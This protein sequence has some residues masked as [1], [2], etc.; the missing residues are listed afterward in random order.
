MAA[1]DQRRA[2]SSEVANFGGGGV[3][4]KTAGL[5]ADGPPNTESDRV[6]IISSDGHA[7]AQMRDW[8]PYIPSRYHEEF[9]EFCDVYDEKGSRNNQ[10]SALAS[11]LDPEVV[12]DWKTRI[13]DPGRH[14]GIFDLKV[15]LDELAYHGAA[16]EVLFPDF[17][18]PFELYSPQLANRLGY[19]RT[20]EQINVA[21]SAY[22]RWLVD[23]CS[24][25]PER[26]AGQACVNW[27]DVDAA[28]AEIRWAKNAGL[29][30]VIL[31]FFS[32]EYPLF[33]PRYDPIWS[34]LEELEMPANSHA[35]ISG[36]VEYNPKMAGFP[37]A[38]VAVALY[39]S[40]LA[41]FSHQILNH[42]I[43]GGVLER[44]PKLQI[45]FT[46]QGTGWVIE[47]CAQMDYSWGGSF[48]RRDVREVVPLAPS[49]YF[50]RQ[51]H[52]GS[53]LFSKA[54]AEAREA[55]GVDK[56]TIGLDYPH[57]EGTWGNGVASH[58]A[59]MKATLGAAHVPPEDARLMM[60]E[61]A[62]KLWGFDRAALQLIVDEIGPS[63]TEI[64]TPPTTDEFPR[65]DVHKPL[66]QVY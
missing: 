34:T 11:R 51:C 20:D 35:A 47:A 13:L 59:Y 29:R 21:N 4:S 58:I 23:Y 36:I 12:D 49:E 14:N 37:N 48:L 39:S 57:H 66:A 8:R 56:I 26:F 54:E 17:G 2:T 52:M 65:G 41:F 7:C 22:N 60:G 53:S 16:A 46:E 50:N 40:G 9:D 25:A 32:V 38:A 64:L 62:I 33:H 18:L 42:V 55:V 19:T 3:V 6:L 30:G 10:P 45:V 44:H 5:K 61:N 1:V 28:I 63:L 43:W 27:D 15:R 24:Q 31:P